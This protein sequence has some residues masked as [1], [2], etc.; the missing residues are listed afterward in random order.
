MAG[1]IDG[2]A[3]VPR[4]H[5]SGLAVILCLAGAGVWLGRKG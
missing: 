5:G 3:P 1:P 2:T 4:G